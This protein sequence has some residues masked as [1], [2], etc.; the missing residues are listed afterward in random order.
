MWGVPGPGG[1]SARY[2]PL[3]TE[4]QTG[5]K[6]L[7]WPNFVAAGN[8]QCTQV[9]CIIYMSLFLFSFHII[10]DEHLTTCRFERT[11]I[12]SVQSIKLSYSQTELHV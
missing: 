10:K 9:L 1:V 11:L 7:P 3:L 8:D 4:S 12:R 5:V 2:T 6:I